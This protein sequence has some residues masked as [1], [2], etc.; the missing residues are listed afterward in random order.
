LEDNYYKAPSKIKPA[1]IG[2][3]VM[4]A[5]S[6]IPY[7]SMVNCACCAGIMLG[8]LASV[9]FYLRS[10]PPDEP[11]LQTK[12]GLILGAFAGI[13]GALI[14]TFITVLIIKVLSKSYF[15]QIYFEIEKNI[16]DMESKGQEIPNLLN[17]IQNALKMLTQEI[18]ETGFS[19][20]L[21][22]LMLVFNTMKDVL[23]GLLGGLIG[24]AVLQKKM[25]AIPPTDNTDTNNR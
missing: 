16:T 1:I 20:L 10:L 23:F 21:T 15:D 4:A 12:H 7:I 25:K 24:I 22:V 8:G 2:G 14:E 11:P 18:A 3:A 13:F 5:T 17:Q 6:V 9:Y 19:F